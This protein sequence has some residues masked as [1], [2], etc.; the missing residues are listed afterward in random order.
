MEFNKA[1]IVMVITF[2]SFD[3]LSH[4]TNTTHPRLTE[5]VAK[6]V[7]KIDNNKAYH[8]LYQTESGYVTL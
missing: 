7:L 3:V 8:Q 5:A 4:D 1:F 6:S 2:F